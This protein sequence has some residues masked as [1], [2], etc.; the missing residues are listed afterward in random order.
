MQF[1]VYDESFSGM[2]NILGGA[3][4]MCYVLLLCE[5]VLF[6]LLVIQ[7]HLAFFVVCAQV[8][9]LVIIFQSCE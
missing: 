6:V 4:I 5:Y 7:Q 9:V 2:R 8:L 1:W 3:R